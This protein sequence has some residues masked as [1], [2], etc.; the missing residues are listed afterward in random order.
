MFEISLRSAP[1]REGEG[2]GEWGFVGKRL[3]DVEFGG[4]LG[5]PAAPLHNEVHPVACLI[6]SPGRSSSEA[7]ECIVVPTGDGKQCLEVGTD[8]AGGVPREVI[9]EV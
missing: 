7:V 6:H 1:R 3:S 2:S 8:G 5:S 9:S 4:S